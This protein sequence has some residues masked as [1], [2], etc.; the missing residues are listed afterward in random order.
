MNRY[1]PS[2]A[3]YA[4]VLLIGIAS[5]LHACA[6]ISP[7]TFNEKLAA[8]YVSVTSIRQ[9]GATL[10]ASKAITPDDGENVLKQTDNARA[11]LDLARAMGPDAG[12]DKL[13]ATLTVLTGLQTYLNAK[14]AK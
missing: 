1:R 4:A 8:G 13:A 2:Y 11:G 14:G 5:M 10:V 9:L 12:T 7:K 6:T 3:M